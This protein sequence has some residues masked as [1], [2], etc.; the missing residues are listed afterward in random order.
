MLFDFP[1]LQNTKNEVMN[2]TVAQRKVMQIALRMM[3]V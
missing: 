2:K 3:M 1:H